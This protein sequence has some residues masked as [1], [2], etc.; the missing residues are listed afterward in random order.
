MLLSLA[1]IT[2]FAL[3]NFWRNIWLSVVTVTIIILTLFS[4]TSL[5]LVNVIT[6]HALEAVKGKFDIALTFK[7]EISL[8]KVEEIRDSFR[9]L[10]YIATTTLI[11]PDESLHIFQEKHANDSTI[12]G[13]LNAL[14]ENPFGATL[15]LNP[16]SIAYYDTLNKRIEEM[17]LTQ[18]VE[19][20]DT[21]GYK[22]IVDRLEAVSGQVQTAG[23]VV[24]GFFALISLLIVFNAIRMGIYSHRDEIAIMRLVGATNWFIRGPFLIEVILYTVAA[25]VIFWTLFLTAASALSPQLNMFLGSLSFD[26]WGYLMVNLWNIVGFETIAILAL[27]ML[28]SWVAMARYLK[29]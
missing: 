21:G 27:T 22:R 10:P 23:Y 5:V 13:A 15:T 24:S 9:D 26:L 29:V 7:P 3:Q 6:D 18:I 14:T 12:M 19:R 4:L 28:S 25:T 1:R 16:T 2:K 11:T 20:T 17:G 8:S